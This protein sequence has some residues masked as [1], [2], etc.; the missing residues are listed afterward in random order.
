MAKGKGQRQILA[1]ICPVCKSQN[2]ITEKN[3]TNTPDK[4]VLKKFCKKC[5]KV[6]AHKESGKLK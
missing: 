6:T 5:R 3:K 2:Y 4:L 1:L